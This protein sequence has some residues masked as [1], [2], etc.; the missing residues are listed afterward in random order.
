MA[1]KFVLKRSRGQFM[2][3]LRSPN[4]RIILTSERYKTRAGALN[5]IKSVKMNARKANPFD[6]R[7]SRNGKP[8]FVLVAANNEVI[9]RSQLYASRSGCIN[10]MAS[11][12][13]NAPGAKTDDQT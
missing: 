5:G 9:G 12:R 4:G 2:F 6:R 10:G 8:C 3:N 11:V 13:R 7:K 1:G